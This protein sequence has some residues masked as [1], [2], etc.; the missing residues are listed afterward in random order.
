[1]WPSSF[2][3]HLRQ[4]VWGKQWAWQ[5]VALWGRYLAWELGWGCLSPR[6]RLAES[7]REHVLGFVTIRREFCNINQVYGSILCDIKGGYYTTSNL[8][9][10]KKKMKKMKGYSKD[11]FVSLRAALLQDASTTERSSVVTQ[12]SEHWFSFNYVVTKVFKAIKKCLTFYHLLA[13][14]LAGCLKFTGM[15][16]IQVFNNLLGCLF[17]ISKH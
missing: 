7:L 3:L 8:P 15:S 17:H 2:T 13:L 5:L 4:H 16:Q 14:V 11:R 6:Q 12:E 9:K 10:K 1:M